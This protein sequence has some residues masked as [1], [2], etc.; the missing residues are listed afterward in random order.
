M[1][2]L[3]EGAKREAAKQKPPTKK[4]P[5]LSQQ[6]IHSIIDKTLW[7]DGPG[8]IGDSPDLATWR[9]CYKCF[10]R[11]SCYQQLTPNDVAK[12][13]QFYS[14]SFSFLSVIPGSPYCLVSF[15]HHILP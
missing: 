4:A 3:L 9:T 2:L 12:N 14:G 6:K 1:N 5:S 10:C 7:K 15:S 8:V 11:W 13:D